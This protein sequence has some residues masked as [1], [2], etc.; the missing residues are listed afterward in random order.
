MVN[1]VK[2][3]NKWKKSFE[4]GNAPT[5]RVLIDYRNYRDTEDWRSTRAVEELCEY[6]LYLE[7]KCLDKGEE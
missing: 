4:E 6:I 2:S 7:R 5:Q 3:R 1:L